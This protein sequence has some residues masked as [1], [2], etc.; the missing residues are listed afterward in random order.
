MKPT[1]EGTIAL[2]MGGRWR[3]SL[4]LRDLSEDGGVLISK[5]KGV[6]LIGRLLGFA[7]AASEDERVPTPS[8]EVPEGADMPTRE[9][10]YG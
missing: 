7:M 5:L 6:L 9:L 2:P 4:K 3:R 10:A 1:W 8:V